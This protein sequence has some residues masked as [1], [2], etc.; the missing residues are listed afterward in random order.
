ML[1]ELQK[2][3]SLDVAKHPMGLDEI[4]EDFEQ[5][6]RQEEEN[7]VKI[8]GVFGMGRSGKTTLAKELFNLKRLD[9]H[10]SCFLTD[11]REASSKG[12]LL[13]MQTKLLKDLVHEK[14]PP[15]F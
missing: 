2:E 13:S 14:D 12:E 1:K 8:I 10:G 15:K 5:H 9:Y 7:R 6:C 4:V 11:V 3:R